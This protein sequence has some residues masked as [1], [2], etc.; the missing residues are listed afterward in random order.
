M[1]GSIEL[2]KRNNIYRCKTRGAMRGE[3]D[4]LCMEWLRKR[5]IVGFRRGEA[6][7]RPSCYKVSVR[8]ATR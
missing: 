7:C 5:D 1:F 4:V 6:G 2:E 8:S 3:C